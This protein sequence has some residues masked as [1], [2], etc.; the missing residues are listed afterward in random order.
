MTL[1]TQV[2]DMIY[3]VWCWFCWKLTGKWWPFG[4]GPVVFPI[5]LWFLPWAGEYIYWDYDPLAWDAG[6]LEGCGK[7]MGNKP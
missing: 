5:Y 6:E 7:D 4:I 1:I 3:K 2:S